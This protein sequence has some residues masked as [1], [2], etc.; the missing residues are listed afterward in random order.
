MQL[1]NYEIQSYKIKKNI[2]LQKLTN[3]KIIKIYNFI[4]MKL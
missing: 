2:K 4:I 1:Q 3:Y